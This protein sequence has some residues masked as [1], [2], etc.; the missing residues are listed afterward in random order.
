ME[1][2]PFFVS[3]A[4]SLV[5]SRGELHHRA[6]DCEDQHGGGKKDGAKD[7]FIG[8]NLHIELTLEVGERMFQGLDNLDWYSLHGA[9]C[10][11]QSDST[12]VGYSFFEI[13]ISTRA[14]C[15][16]SA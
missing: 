14:S 6:G 11:G 8:G 7:F 1:G 3:S 2:Q 15:D 16:A 12:S 13:S 4:G 9:E 10:R 5:D